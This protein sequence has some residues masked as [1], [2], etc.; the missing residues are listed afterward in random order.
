M[1]KLGIIVFSILLL[2]L[3]ACKNGFTS[4]H[5][6]TGKVTLS[7]ASE[8]TV[9]PV[10]WNLDDIEN[11]N[12][13][14]TPASGSA[15]TKSMTG[16]SETFILPAGTYSVNVTGTPISNDPEYSLYGETTIEVE[17]ES[18]ND[19]TVFVGLLKTETGNGSFSFNLNLKNE[20]VFS[21]NTG[22]QV[23]TNGYG[24]VLNNF[25]VKAYLYSVK[26]SSAAPIKL[27]VQA[28]EE[29]DYF[30]FSITKDNIPSGFYTLVVTVDFSDEIVLPLN[31]DVLVEI[32][33]GLTTTLPDYDERNFNGKVQRS[34]YVT[35]DISCA[36]NN[37]LSPSSKKYMPE[38][39]DW[40]AANKDQ[41][42]I[43]D[44][45]FITD[46]VDEDASEYDKFYALTPK[47]NV[48]VI[49]VRR[50]YSEHTNIYVDGVKFIDYEQEKINVYPKAEDNYYWFISE[51]DEAED[52]IIDLQEKT[53]CNSFNFKLDNINLVLNNVKTD[54]FKEVFVCRED[55]GSVY[56]EGTSI[57]YMTV[58]FS[59]GEPDLGAYKFTYRRVD[60]S[61]T[62]KTYCALPFV[63]GN[64]TDGYSIECY[65]Q[66]GGLADINIF[67]QKVPMFDIFGPDYIT[68]LNK[69]Q[70]VS[71]VAKPYSEE[72][73]IDSAT[74]A[75]FVNGKLIDFGENE[76]T[77]ELSL[78]FTSENY[79]ELGTNT[80][81]CV[82]GYGGEYSS[83]TLY[84]VCTE[85]Q[86][87][88]Y[89]HS[90]Q[91][92]WS[93]DYKLDD[94][95][96]MNFDNLYSG[97]LTAFCYDR[98]N[99]FYG[100]FYNKSAKTVDILKLEY[101]FETG[102][103]SSEGRMVASIILKDYDSQLI[104]TR[105]T[106]D[107]KSVYCI[108]TSNSK[109]GYAH[110][111]FEGNKVYYFPIDSYKEYDESLEIPLLPSF[112]EVNDFETVTALTY[113]SANKLLYIAGN[114]ISVKSTNTESY[115]D[116]DV[117]TYMTDDIEVWNYAY[118]VNSYQITSSVS[119][120]KTF[121]SVKEKLISYTDDDV[122][123]QNPELSQ[124][125]VEGFTD[126]IEYPH[127]NFRIETASFITDIAVN[128]DVV[129]AIKSVFA[130]YA[131]SSFYASEYIEP[132]LYKSKPNEY[133][134]SIL[135]YNNET[136]SEVTIPKFFNS[137]RNNNLDNT[138]IISPS[139]FIAVKPKELVICS[140]SSINYTF[141][142]DLDDETVTATECD[143][144]YCFDN[145]LSG[146][147]NPVI[148]THL[149]KNISE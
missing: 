13:V 108:M 67:S 59:D 116:Y 117:K 84:V 5:E 48:D 65:T 104:P 33:D 125:A 102:F 133:F 14:F 3:S 57:P 72:S 73:F 7:I 76:A 71:Y 22:G 10:D 74:F 64:E 31:I 61:Y 132:E 43:A 147:G 50:N 53:N 70:T 30:S 77:A 120:G 28:T 2:S 100:S 29:A 19:F 80:I 63:T 83:K 60:G 96:T 138:Y 41:W 106:S 1:K 56:E 145:A 130:R 121:R 94:G 91:S 46:P 12:I 20:T 55:F 11:W 79:V 105:M 36:N 21:Q 37:G 38:M 140:A 51:E 115:F 141:N 4:K 101:D 136:V 126:I 75:W 49:P 24:A 40:L 25:G 23:S 58:N 107:G 15:V 129:Y 8:R 148:N 90:E 27:I 86:Q 103:Y 112:I 62:D 85:G 111:G 142:V 69:N 124:S 99:N 93:S 52:L 114:N 16:N 146:S 144:S 118:F 89:F 139:R 119:E 134:G 128:N 109:F 82:V 6:A 127:Y 44:L 81:T 137:I 123:T 68:V 149:Y 26:D 110:F 34:F 122:F 131:D 135:V 39:L 78:N 92:K 87:N 35:N 18:D 9:S 113:D 54:S 95:R 97:V 17:A 42:Q 47:I 98:K 143:D 88:V 32:A 45:Y 66:L